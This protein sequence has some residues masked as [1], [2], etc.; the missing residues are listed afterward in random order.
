M[1]DWPDQQKVRLMVI[2]TALCIE[3]SCMFLF[4]KYIAVFRVFQDHMRQEQIEWSSGF[5][6]VQRRDLSLFYLTSFPPR[7]ERPKWSWR[8]T[9][10]PVDKIKTT[11]V[12]NSEPTTSRR[13]RHSST[14]LSEGIRRWIGWVTVLSKRNKWSLNNGIE[15]YLMKKNDFPMEG[16]GRSTRLPIPIK[17]W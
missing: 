17:G 13:F 5:G 16:E 6:Y 8:S 2:V 12:R 3:Y 7:V 1:L 10:I 15:Y 4:Q 9:T 14:L 11:S